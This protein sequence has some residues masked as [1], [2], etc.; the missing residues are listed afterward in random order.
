MLIFSTRLPVKD[1]LTKEK[2]FELV[3]RWNQGSPHDRIDGVAW[4]GG[5][6]H[7]WGNEVR[8]LEITEHD[9]IAAARFVRNEAHG[10]NWSIEFILRTDRREIGIYLS[11]EATENTVYFHK[12][13]KPPYFLKLLMRENVLGSDGGLTIS[14]YPH[15]FGATADEQQVLTQLCLEDAGAFRLPVVYLT[16]DWFTEQCV[17]DEGE[18]PRRLCG[19]AHVLVESD[20]D[21][22]R[23][24]KDLCHGKNVYNGGM[25]V[26]FPSVSAA[27]KRFIPY[28]G[29]DVEKVMTQIVRMIFRY[30]NQ[31]KRERLDTWDGIQMMQMRRQTKQLL[32]E[33]RRIEENR[34]QTSKEKEQYWDEYVK[35]QTQVEA[36]TEQN[37]RLQSE[38]AVLRARV[39]SMGENPLLYYGDEKEFYQ[40]EMLEFV[41]TALSEKLDR[42][43]KEKDRHL[44]CADVLQD[45]LNANECEEIQAQRQ[46]ELK[47]VLK[48]YRT[49][50]PEIQSTLIDVGF[51]I[52]EGKH[53]KLTYYD[54]ERYTVTMAKS[55]SDWRGGENLISE[56]RKRI[57]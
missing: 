36:L 51:R 33:K 22:S 17:V 50:T 19:V 15:S 55:G 1:T 37:A 25:A 49:L 34:K 30:M 35:A 28:D 10:V 9:E 41:R 46:T 45:L 43:P 38:L 8:M 42:L 20:K 24:L 53:Y 13:F 56:I 32:A 48:G 14:E 21:V 44:R 16:R 6:H 31:Q 12:E 54:D 23:T 26:Y 7:R 27:A 3:V 11:R 29:M 39:D 40:G 52:T 47:R 57:Y 4:N 2:F 18:L 5:S